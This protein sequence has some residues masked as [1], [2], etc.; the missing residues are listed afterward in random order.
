M[1]AFIAD[2]RRGISIAKFCELA[3]M[4]ETTFWDVFNN[5]SAPLTAEIQARVNR[6]WDLWDGGYVRVE[7]AGHRVRVR[8]EREPKLMLRK[9]MGIELGPGGPTM[10]LGVRKRSDYS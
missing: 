10:R 1:R 8:L 3:H 9:R 5:G 6:A 2:S 7:K 4:H